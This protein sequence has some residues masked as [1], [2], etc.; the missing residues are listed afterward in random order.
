[1]PTSTAHSEVPCGPRGMEQDCARFHLQMGAS[2][3]R[4]SEESPREPRLRHFGTPKV[5]ARTDTRKKA[6]RSRADWRAAGLLQRAIGRGEESRR[7]RRNDEK[8]S[9]TGGLHCRLMRWRAAEHGRWSG[10]KRETGTDQDTAGQTQGAE[11]RCAH[12]E[13]A[14]TNQE[15]GRGTEASRGRVGAA[16]RS[17]NRETETLDG[18]SA[19]VPLDR[20]DAEQVTEQAAAWTGKASKGGGV[21]ED[22]DRRETARQSCWNR[23]G[24]SRARTGRPRGLRGG[25]RG[26]S[27]E[28]VFGN[29]ADPRVGS[30]MQQARGP[31][32]GANRRGREKR[33]GRNERS[34]WHGFAEDEEAACCDRVGSG[35]H[36]EIRRRGDIWNP[37]RGRQTHEVH[38]PTDQQSSGGSVQMPARAGDCTPAAAWRLGAVRVCMRGSPKA[39]ATC[40]G[41]GF[42][43]RYVEAMTT[44]RTTRVRLGKAEV[45]SEHTAPTWQRGGVDT[46]GRGGP[47]AARPRWLVAKAKRAT[48]RAS[49]SRSSESYDFARPGPWTT[50]TSWVA[51]RGAILRSN[52]PTALCSSL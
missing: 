30:G 12:G 7:G 40:Q 49:S 14:S 25:E 35:P 28:D 39:T 47:A 26:R 21:R 43:I 38:R 50:E 37:K 24:E 33:R 3:R 8:E 1:M 31:G 46:G 32:A 18:A 4:Q 42:Y 9:S 45:V 11:R 17:V 29:R 10:W 44:G 27:Q 19:A 52:E 13:L 23:A 51:A 6:L 5:G 15:T 34:R 22:E 48:T 16:Q 36:Q 20:G 41:T 2:R